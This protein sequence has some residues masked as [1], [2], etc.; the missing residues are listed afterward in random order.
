GDPVAVIIAETREQAK[1]ASELIEIDYQPLP[2]V[3][4]VADAVKPKAPQVWEQAKGNLCYDWGLGDKAAGDA[5]LA[6]AHHISKLDMDKNGKFV[7]L[8]VET[9]ANMGAYLSTF[10]TCVPT[11]LYATLLAGVYTT[12]AIWANVKAVFTN[13]VPVDAYRG[14]GRPEA[15]YLLERIVDVAARDMKMDPAEIRRQNFIKPNQFPYQTPVALKYDTG[16][17]DATLDVAMKMIDYK[18][19]AKRR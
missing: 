16:N 19:F 8:K 15:T 2:S 7:A 3:V 14:A 12:P 4:N 5:A 18:G 17:Y 10:S 9:L 13:T 1:D 6:K 11:Y